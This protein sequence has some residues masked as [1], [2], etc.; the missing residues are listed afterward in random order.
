MVAGIVGAMIVLILIIAMVCVARRQEKKRT[1]R[2]VTV[3]PKG[4]NRPEYTSTATLPTY[5]STIA[6]PL[7]AYPGTSDGVVMKT[8]TT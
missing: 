4:P 2:G 1:A 8:R 3:W 7:P 5:E 6:A